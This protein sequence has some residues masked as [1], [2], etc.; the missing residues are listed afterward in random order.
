[1]A[2]YYHKLGL[3]PI[4]VSGKVC[5]EGI[6]WKQYQ[7]VL[8]EI[9]HRGVDRNDR[10]GTGTRSIFAPQ[11]RF[12]LSDGFPAMTTKRLAFKAVKSELLW[13]I[14]GSSSDKRLAEINGTE[15]TIWTAN[16]EADYWK[17]KAEFDGDLGRVY[18]VQWRHWRNGTNNM[19]DES[20]L[21]VSGRITR[22]ITDEIKEGKLT[23]SDRP[24][25]WYRRFMREC[26]SPNHTDQLADVIQRIKDKPWDRR[27]VISAWNPGETDQMALPPCHMIFQFY[28]ANDQLSCHMTQRSCDMFLGVPFNIAS[29]ALLTHMVAQVCDLQVGEL[30]VTLNDAHIYNNH[31]DQVQEQLQRTPGE[32]PTLWMNPDIKDIDD[33]TMDDIKLENYNPQA[34]IKA[35][36]AV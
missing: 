8:T 14:E 15:K 33:F 9:M 32:L 35:E 4:P 29:Y 13:M 10:T 6:Q 30:V 23:E 2:L 28:V 26:P 12:R 18:G 31:F 19:Y 3:M 22:E 1:M 25:E 20:T 34:T 21:Q 24:E 11:M 17:P 27:H 36:M 7:D 5:V 16:A